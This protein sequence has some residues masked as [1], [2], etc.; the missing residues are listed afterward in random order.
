MKKKSKILL[1]IG[2]ALAL[3]IACFSLAYA[4]NVEKLIPTGI[5]VNTDAGAQNASKLSLVSNLPKAQWTAIVA[6]IIKMALQI[7]GALSVASFTYG[8]VMMVTAQGNDEK[9]KKGRGVITWS[10]LALIIIAVSYAIVLGITE[11][12]FFG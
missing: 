5:V 1:I 7:T 4:A 8:G 11:L 12:K 3:N 9:I 6:A 10:L 2:I